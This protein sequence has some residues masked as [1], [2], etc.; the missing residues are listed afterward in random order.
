[1]AHLPHGAARNAKRV[2]GDEARKEDHGGR[3]RGLVGVPPASL[4]LCAATCVARPH[5]RVIIIHPARYCT[6]SASRWRRA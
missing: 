6:G 4:P 2:V 5:V 3:R 1:M